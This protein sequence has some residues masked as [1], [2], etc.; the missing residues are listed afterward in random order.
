[1][2]KDFEA[3]LGK[4]RSMAKKVS[5]NNYVAYGHVA[6]A[7]LGESARLY[8]GVCVN[9]KCNLGNCAE[10]A[11]ILEMLKSH[12]HVIKKMVVFSH[13]GCVYA[14]CGKCR[15]LM[16]MLSMDNMNAQILMPD[17]SVMKLAELLP[18]PFS[19]CEPLN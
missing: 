17:Y 5:L 10:Q 18:Y 11:A 14:P 12:E 8:T 15:E 3:L 2:D 9:S 4:A 6:C 16:K 13:K 7:I 19:I 1:M